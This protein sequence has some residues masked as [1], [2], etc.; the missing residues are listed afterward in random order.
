V[1]P[2]QRVL[3]ATLVAWAG[4]VAYIASVAMLVPQTGD[5][6]GPD[7]LIGW[8]NRLIVGGY[9]LDRHIAA[10]AIS[11]GDDPMLGRRASRHSS[12]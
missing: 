7:V 3:L 1:A 4:F 12:L 11:V 5:P 6:F 10:A 9:G 8:Q 2:G